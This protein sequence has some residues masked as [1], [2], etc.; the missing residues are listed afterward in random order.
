MKEN[1]KIFSLKEP[2]H[3]RIE[4]ILN[5]I[6][7]IEIFTNFQTN[8]IYQKDEDVESFDFSPFCIF[9]TINER[10]LSLCSE[11]QCILIEIKT[12]SQIES[13]LSKISNT[14]LVSCTE[15]DHEKFSISIK[16]EE[17]GNP[18]QTMVNYF[19]SLLTP[20][21]SD[22]FTLYSYL[23]LCSY[24]LMAY[25]LQ[26]NYFHSKCFRDPS[27]FEYEINFQKF[28]IKAFLHLRIIGGCANGH[29]SLVF[30]KESCQLFAY[31][32][33]KNPKKFLIEKKFYQF[34]MHHCI[35]KGIGFVSTIG[36]EY[37]I[38]ME[39]MCNGS[40]LRLIQKNLLDDTMRTKILIRI[41]CAIDYLHS[42]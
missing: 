21:E 34:N 39:Y 6:I 7:K 36:C 37:G 20:V 25:F 9:N 17:S 13:I 15:K 5:N 32:S 3:L 2:E 28:D 23:E 29:V 38:V 14:I 41:L 42:K 19:K 26:R 24:S 11:N 30:H 8:L 18:T 16:S 35:V 31:K 12:N 27:F 4:V 22:K 33:I 40:V 10:Y 1:Q